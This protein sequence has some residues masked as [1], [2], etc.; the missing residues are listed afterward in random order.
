MK[1]YNQPQIKT[2]SINKKPNFK[3]ISPYLKKQAEVALSKPDTRTLFAKLV[4]ITG[5]A[6]VLAWTKTLNNKEDSQSLERINDSWL[7]CRTEMYLNPETNEHFLDVT[8]QSD[9]TESFLWTKAQLSDANATDNVQTFSEDNKELFLS[10]KSNNLYLENRANKALESILFQ[11]KVLENAKDEAKNFALK[12]IEDKWNTLVKQADL[13]KSNEVTAELYQKIA[14]IY[15]SFILSNY[16]EKPTK[17]NTEPTVELDTDEVTNDENVIKLHDTELAEEIIEEPVEV[18]ENPVA[19]QSQEIVSAGVPLRRID[20]EKP[21]YCAKDEVPVITP[22]IVGK[23]ELVPAKIKIKET[24]KNREFLKAFR[25][26]F[27]SD[28]LLKPEHYIDYIDFMV[29][30]YNSYS[31]N[32]KIRE[33]LLKDFADIDHLNE[34]KLYHDYTN[35]EVEKI[36]FLNFR[37]FQFNKKICGGTITKE[38]FERLKSYQDNQIKYYRINL[39]A[40]YPFKNNVVLNFTPNVSKED[41]LKLMLDAYKIAFNVQDKRMI[42]NVEPAEVTVN[43]VKSELAQKLAKDPD[44][45]ANIIKYIGVDKTSPEFESIISAVNDGDTE[46]AGVE[47]NN[48][49]SKN[50]Y[51]YRLNAVTSLL[52]MPELDEYF[53]GIH[54]KMRFLERFIFDDM[55]LMNKNIRTLKTEMLTQLNTINRLLTNIEYITIYNYEAKNDDGTTGYKKGPNFVIEYDYDNNLIFALNN[56]MKIHTI[57]KKP[58]VRSRRTV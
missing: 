31:K 23:I 34:I 24:E 58:K 6:S 8:S 11:L 49:L 36:G 27:T 7:Q 56:D 5:L 1:I 3:A 12:S 13:V 48:L 57:F 4:G 46:E 28:S 32:P 25:A 44:D 16:V 21:D 41:R 51:K 2:Q 42:G 20:A 55:A 50:G 35:G 54:G 15:K 10:D 29:E 37:N 18:I 19:E 33:F 14:D 43:A 26:A 30:I 47:I 38:E 9:E 53:D 17:P 45:Y 39:D 52:K 22:K 40:A